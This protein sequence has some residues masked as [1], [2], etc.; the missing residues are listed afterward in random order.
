[1]HQINLAKIFLVISIAAFI[2][3]T[4]DAGQEAQVI[5]LRRSQRSA[6]H[7]SGKHSSDLDAP[8]PC[9]RMLWQVCGSDGKNY[10][11]ECLFNCAAR[12]RND[13]KLVKRAPCGEEEEEDIE[14]A[15]FHP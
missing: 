11:N 15:P 8:C 9:P 3:S 7:G 12:A 1:M 10:D 14:V 2:I 6:K 4:I 5:R 13:L